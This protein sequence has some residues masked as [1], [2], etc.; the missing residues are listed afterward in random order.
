M[1]MNLKPLII[2]IFVLCSSCVAVP[3]LSPKVTAEGN[4]YAW[5]QVEEC[6]YLR[7][8]S[9][10]TRNEIK[11]SLYVYLSFSTSLGA[12]LNISLHSVEFH[13]AFKDLKPD[14]RIPLNAAQSLV[15]YSD[16]T[17]SRRA[18]DVHGAV[19]IWKC[20]DGVLAGQFEFLCTATPVDF[21]V[22]HGIFDLKYPY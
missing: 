2:C 11:D 5:C 3:Q 8:T 19:R 14:V 4:N 1:T 20:G 16:G 18:S 15:R 17:A 21:A 13:L 9:S 22:E 12:V 10:I 7:T 6:N